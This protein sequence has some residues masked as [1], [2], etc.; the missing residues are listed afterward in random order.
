MARNHISG[1]VRVEM[2]QT[3]LDQ[4]RPMGL[5]AR[6]RSLVIHTFA[7]QTQRQ[8]VRQG[9]VLRE[10]EPELPPDVELRPL[11]LPTPEVWSKAWDRCKLLQSDLYP[12]QCTMSNV[13]I[14]SERLAQALESQ[15][16]ALNELP[17]KLR[18]LCDSIGVPADSP[19]LGHARMAV[20]LLAVLEIQDAR[21]RL[22]SLAQARWSEIPE[23]LA[24]YIRGAR[25]L[26]P[27]LSQ[28]N[29]QQLGTLP[30]LQETEP[31]LEEL[32][33]VAALSEQARPLAPVIEL[34]KKR[35]L[36]LVVDR[37]GPVVNPPPPKA[38]RLAQG[39]LSGSD[40]RQAKAK[41]QELLGLLDDPKVRV[42]LSYEIWQD[43]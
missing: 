14:V 1:A 35:T 7:E 22:E 37:A 28:D 13:E 26:L 19:R 8:L 5:P 43:P 3:W 42:N 29:L 30:K 40:G 31:V 9:L 6:L 15:R 4:P 38:R 36:Q 10:F 17:Q 20:E 27:A 21:E 34:A 39:S 16:Q 23:E 12:M 41:L 2:L 24:A 25:T 32:R 11:Q 18:A 33:Q